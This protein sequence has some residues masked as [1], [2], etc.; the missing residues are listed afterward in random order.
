MRLFAAV[1]G[2]K[3]TM[4]VNVEL[5]DASGDHQY[6]ACWRAIMHEADGEPKPSLLSTLRC[7]CAFLSHSSHVVDLFIVYNFTVLFHFGLVLQECCWCTTLT[8]PHKTNRS[9]TGLI[10]S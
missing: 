10:F 5:W 7:I 4:P 6:E 9:E 1:G 2:I 3:G 8:P